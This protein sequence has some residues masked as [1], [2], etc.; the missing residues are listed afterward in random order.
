[1]T[2]YIALVECSETGRFGIV[3]PDFPGCV[4][5]G[6]TFEEA[7]RRGTEALAFHVDSMRR[8]GDPIPE[9][10]DLATVRAGAG[11]WYDV[12]GSVVALV[13][14]VPHVTRTVRINI[15]MDERLI[16]DIDAVTSNR[17]GFLAEAA[18]KALDGR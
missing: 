1:M 15:S 13:P 3:F 9:P 7:V 18:R 14:L 2:T 11:D 5:V 12:D 17:S 8:D 4:S 10:G 16:A 6:G